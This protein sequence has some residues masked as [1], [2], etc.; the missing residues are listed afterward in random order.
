MVLLLRRRLHALRPVGDERVRRHPTRA[1]RRARDGRRRGRRRDRRH[2]LAARARAALRR[3]RARTASCPTTPPPRPAASGSSSGTPRAHDDPTSAR[4]PEDGQHPAGADLD[5]LVA[6]VDSLPDPGPGIRGT[7][8]YVLTH[9]STTSRRGSTAWSAHGAPVGPPPPGVAASRS[10]GSSRASS[11][12]R[13]SPSRADDHQRRP[14]LR[15]Q[16]RKLIAG[17]AADRRCC[18]S[19]RSPSSRSSACPGWSRS[20]ARHVY[21]ILFVAMMLAIDAAF[22]ALLYRFGRSRGRPRPSR[23]GSRPDR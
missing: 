5:D 11:C 1:R 7:S 10:A 19:T 18:T 4:P 6:V 12:S 8:A 22:S 9:A 14:L 20:A 16:P 21:A 15:R 13:S 17:L 3:A 2:R 23:C